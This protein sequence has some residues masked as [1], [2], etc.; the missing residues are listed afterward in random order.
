MPVA[1]PR[2]AATPARGR[3]VRWWR[4]SVFLAAHAPLALAMASAEVVSTVHAL[5]TLVVGLLWAGSGR[6]PERVAYVGAYIA[7]AEVLWRMTDARVFWEFG[8]YAT[9]L[10]F[11]VALFRTGRSLRPPAIGIYF[12]LLLPSA[13]F[14]LLDYDFYQA[15]RELSFNLSGPFALTICVFFFSQLVVTRLS[16]VRLFLALLAPVI[17]M[18]AIALS[19]TLSVASLAA[20]S[21]SSSSATSGGF[22]PN[23]VSAVLGLGVLFAFFLIQESGLPA[24]LRALIFLLMIGLAAQ[25]ALTFSR[26]GLYMAGGAAVAASL[27]LMKDGTSRLKLLVVAA[28]CFAAAKYVILPRLDAVTGGSLVA[29]FED[30]GLTG[31]EEIAAVDLEVWG[32]NPILGVG[33][34]QSRLYRGGMHAHTEFTRALAEHGALGLLAL[35]LL[36]YCGWKAFREKRTARGRAL[37]AAFIVWA[38]LFLGVNGMR[39]VAPSFAFGLAFL[40]LARSRNGA[41]SPAAAGG[42]LA[43]GPRAPLAVLPGRIA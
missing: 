13:I 5:L 3:T 1:G 12:L 15:R 6:K 27:F 37:S 22:G 10:L 32:E 28:L 17:G 19:G 36:L 42:R 30:V 43:T 33:P 25:S 21:G 26:G 8:K 38:M 14:T 16:L 34:G 31:R 35:L 20:L 39:L 24:F 40:R 7:G 9:A 41:R 29:R 23:Q 11:L 4:P 18:G 2:T